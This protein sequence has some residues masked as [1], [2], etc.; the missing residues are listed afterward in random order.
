MEVHHNPHVEKKKF[1][2]YFL[3]FLMIFLAVTLGFFAENIREHSTEMINGKRYLEAYR[4]ELDQQHHTINIFKKTFQRKIMVCDSMKNI[5]YLGQEA[6]KAD[7]VRRLLLPCLKVIE[8]S[9]HTSAYQ[10]M[11]NSGALRYIKNVDLRDSMAVYNSLIETTLN[12]NAQLVQAIINNT[13][14]ISGFFDFHDIVSS[15]TSM[16]YEI[17][18]HIPNVEVSESLTK[19]QRNRI[20][21]FWESYVVQARSDLGRVRSLDAANEHLLQMVNERISK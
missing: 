11:V 21:F 20:V 1:K 9:F 15:D 4:D 16:S 6:K 3:E 17:E 7:D 10:Q 8:V 18:H 13:T 19:E 12:Y 5:F 14:E 2:E